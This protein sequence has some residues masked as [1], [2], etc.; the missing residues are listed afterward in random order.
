MS[1]IV[2]KNA[3]K[4]YIL[5]ELTIYCNKKNYKRGKKGLATGRATAA[6]TAIKEMKIVGKTI[7]THW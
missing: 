2:Q 6:A 3:F 5:S 4:E 1:Q 7:D